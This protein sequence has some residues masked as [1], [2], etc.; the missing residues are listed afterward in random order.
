MDGS[1]RLINPCEFETWLRL[2]GNLVYPIEYDILCAMDRVYCE[3]ANKEV[4]DF[5]SRKQD[6]QKREVTSNKP[7]PHRGK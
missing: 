4:E 3:E 7:R 1:Y 2:T 6:E 5:R